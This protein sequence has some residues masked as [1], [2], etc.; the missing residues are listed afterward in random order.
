MSPSGASEPGRV[1][2]RTY[3]RGSFLG[4]ASPILAAFMASM[5]MRGWQESAARDMERDAV[6]MSRQGYRIVSSEE[7][8]YPRFGATYFK[9]TY[10]RADSH[11]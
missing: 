2:V 10:E 7:L 5:G 9:V 11:G 4:L 1:I 8:G 6:E 3:G